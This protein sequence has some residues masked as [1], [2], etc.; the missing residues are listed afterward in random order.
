MKSF[1]EYD[2]TEEGKKIDK[3][4]KKIKM[5]PFD[6]KERKRKKALHKSNLR[7]NNI[8]G[9]AASVEHDIE[10]SKDTAM[11]K[12][13][14]DL[15]VP[16]AYFKHAKLH[17]PKEKI[18]KVKTLFHMM[19]K[20]S[21]SFRPPILVGES[22]IEEE[23]YL[24]EYAHMD[25]FTIHE[26]GGKDFV[27]GW[28]HKSGKIVD[29]TDYDNYHVKQVLKH[30]SKFGLN[31][32]KILGIFEDSAENMD[33][34]DPKQYAE[35]QYDAIEVGVVDNDVYL[36][37]VLQKKGWCMFVIDKTHGSIAGW[38][39]K[40][41]KS[42]AKAM[43]D[44]YLPY[45]TRKD[46]KLFEVKWVKPFKPKYITNKF[47]WYDWLQG[48]AKRKYVSK[49]AQFRES[50]E[51]VIWGIPPKDKDETLLLTTGT[52][53]K[54]I[55][56][57]SDAMKLLKFLVTKHGVKKARIQELDVEVDPSDMFRNPFG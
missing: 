47:D 1:K 32:K 34:P 46:L 38:D 24:K 31:K 43:D 39:E 2:T 6:R 30:S 55:T 18:E 44:K 19:M 12:I 14:S 23:S 54:R 51:Y 3:I 42:A 15:G 36:E 22:V 49:M 28:V 37:E 45:E 10:E 25:S 7:W 11:I 27:K 29:T 48:K 35:D 21:S 20:T 26:A 53:G 52:D 5:R 13:L 41:T 16:D 33:A 4:L 50:V 8:M 56:K 17:V 9:I 40:S 57:K